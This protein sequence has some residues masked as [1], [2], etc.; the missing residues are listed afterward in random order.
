MRNSIRSSARYR[1]FTL[2]ICTISGKDIEVQQDGPQS[3]PSCLIQ[4]K[5]TEQTLSIQSKITEIANL[6][7]LQCL[8]CK[9]KFTSLT[10]LR[11][12]MAFHIGWY[13]YRCKLCDFKCFFK[14][15]CVTHCNKIHNTQNDRA[16]IAEIVVEMPQVKYECN[17]DVVT[18]ANAEKKTDDPDIAKRTASSSQPERCEGADDS[19]GANARV[20][21]QSEGTTRTKGLVIDL[22]GDVQY[23]N[24]ITE[25]TDKTTTVCTNLEEYMACRNPGKL[26]AHPDLKRMVMEVILGSNDANSAVKQEDSEKKIKLDI[27]EAGGDTRNN[28]NSTVAIDASSTTYTALTEGSKFQRP[29]R[30]RIKPL[31]KDFVYDLKDMQFRKET[32]KSS[33]LFQLGKTSTK[34]RLNFCESETLINARK[35]VKLY[36][37]TLQAD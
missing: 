21:V 35:K 9:R 10:S 31:N 37:K 30:K 12:H 11:R 17:K 14:C 20:V 8:L 26:D 5:E 6:R 36:K 4:P 13:R 18:D 25:D 34:H 16:L 24:V 3:Q 19:S 32:C 22:C 33:S 15:D 23:E 27:N 7:K 2:I 29:L 28:E 1:G